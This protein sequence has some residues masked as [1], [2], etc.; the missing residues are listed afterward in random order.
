MDDS[1]IVEIL[2]LMKSKNAAGVLS[3]LNPQRAAKIS[4]M[5]IIRE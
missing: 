1:I 4:R 3:T 2:P 5:I